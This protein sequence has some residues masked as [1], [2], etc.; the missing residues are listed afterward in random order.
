MHA[1]VNN[2]N[3]VLVSNIILKLKTKILLHRTSLVKC[4]INRR[5]KHQSCGKVVKECCKTA[6]GNL[7]FMDL[8]NANGYISKFQIIFFF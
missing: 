4:P 1:T 6:F 5:G 8:F 2:R 3:L 7:N